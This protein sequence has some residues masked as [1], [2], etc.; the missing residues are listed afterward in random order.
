MTVFEF[1][2]GTAAEWTSANPVLRAGEPGLATD[3]GA[4][5]IGDGTSHW[6]DLQGIVGG[7]LTFADVPSTT[8]STGT[9]G[10]LAKDAD[11][12]Y[13]CVSTNNWVRIPTE[14]FGFGMSVVQEATSG[15]GSFPITL[16]SPVTAGNTLVIVAS[17]AENTTP[18]GV[19]VD[20]PTLDG[21]SVTGAYTVFDPSG[22][23][24]VMSSVTPGVYGSVWVLPNCPAGSVVAFGT[25]DGFAQSGHVFEVS[26]LGTAP[27]VDVTVSADGDDNLPTSGTTAVAASPAFVV[28]FSVGY[29]LGM[30][31]VEGTTWQWRYQSDSPFAISGYHL[32]LN[33]QSYNW[34][35]I[36]ASVAPWSAGVVSIVPG[37]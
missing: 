8:T 28:G 7:S 6:I 13:V 31:G 32:G 34:T 4:F 30:Y 20:S 5:K 22:L 33:R 14:G 2:R 23:K 9:T 3:T 25:V 10:Q 15:A 18:S 35:T 12:L 26:G 11:H 24:A 17:G 36:G 27:V 16:A 29:G 19:L 37:P 1:R 21:S